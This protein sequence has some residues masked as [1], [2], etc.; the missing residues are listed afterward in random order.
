V[1]RLLKKA[2]ELNKSL[3]QFFGGHYISTFF[4]VLFFVDIPEALHDKRE[5]DIVNR[6]CRGPCGRAKKT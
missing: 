3:N 5:P 4:F 6:A 1:K 2:R